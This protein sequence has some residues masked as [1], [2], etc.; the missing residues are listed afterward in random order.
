MHKMIDFVSWHNERTVN[1]IDFPEECNCN[2]K[3]EWYRLKQK[4]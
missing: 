3:E 4:G 2:L 1:K